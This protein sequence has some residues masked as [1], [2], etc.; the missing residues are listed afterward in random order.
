[1]SMEELIIRVYCLVDEIVNGIVEKRKL[2]ERG[3]KPKL[4]DSE[5]IT[6][7]IIG[8]FQ[9]IDTDKGVWE[10]F[11]N[12]WIGWFPEMGSRGNFAKQAGNLWNI[13]QEVQRELGKR[14]GAYSDLLHLTDGFPMPVCK[15]KRGNRSRIFRGEAEYGY[16]ASK[17]EK[18]YGLKGNV[19]I[20]SEGV[21]TN[22]TVT[23]AN[24][25]ER[26]SLWDLVGGIK[27]VVI[28]DKGLIGKDYREELRQYTG[29]ELQTAVRSN[30]KENRSK[31]YIKWLVSTRRL[32]ETVI[33][34]LA[35]RFKIEKVRARNVLSLTNRIA[36]KVLS[37][38]VGVFINKEKGNKP[39]QFD[40]LLQS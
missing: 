12:H 7:E 24:I 32:V 1:M 16:C 18:Y 17:D 20:S 19:M 28:A 22:I 6:M 3:Y 40:L 30:M 9:G 29:I 39:L 13:K 23:A 35:E 5:V 10:Y 4:T 31:E 34:Q 14:L 21:I 11:R 33:G 15:Y 25:D 38:T 37:H 36:R 27:G 26:E 8:E 2:R